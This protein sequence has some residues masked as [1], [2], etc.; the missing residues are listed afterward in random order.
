MTGEVRGQGGPLVTDKRSFSGRKRFP[1]VLTVWVDAGT[2]P[3]P[4]L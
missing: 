4:Q 1:S 2:V 3:Q